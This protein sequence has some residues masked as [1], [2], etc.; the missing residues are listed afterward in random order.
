MKVSRHSIAR[1][2]D[3]HQRYYNRFWSEHALHY[4]FW[5][6]GT[7]T[8]SEAVINT[9]Q[10][11]VDVLAI[12]SDDVVLDAGCG[13]GGTAIHIAETTNASVV[14][15][16][17]SEVQLR[18][19]WQRA[20]SSR[21]VQLL[22]FSL[23]DYVRTEFSDATFSKV[24]GIESVCHA[25]DKGA[26]LHEAHRIM[27][28]GGRIAIVDAFLTREPLSR[29]GRFIYERVL[30]GWVLPNLSTV[31]GFFDALGNSGFRSIQFLNM[32]SYVQKSVDRI[33]RHSR[34]TAPLSIA[35]SKLG[36]SP[37]NVAARYQRDLFGQGLAV[38]GV[39]VAERC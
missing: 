30:E 11:V 33:Y 21:A 34:I 36:L 32:Q 31:S 9:N 14:G 19:A 18:Q 2:Y 1:Y 15:I 29:R 4:G 8:L 10:F 39:F 6:N 17:L 7:E 35:R 27:K 25:E 23:Q 12:A 3:T 5:Y 13:V 38:Y 24:L 26:F 22:E 37:K 20:L 16:T 28:P